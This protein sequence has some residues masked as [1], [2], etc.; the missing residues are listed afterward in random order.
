MTNW[1]CVHVFLR[2]QVVSTFPGKGAGLGSSPPVLA[3][4]PAPSESVSLTKC[5]H[6]PLSLDPSAPDC[7]FRFF[8]SGQHNQSSVGEMTI[9]GY[10]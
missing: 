2:G 5:L 4:R 3:G 8:P 9:P 10:A 6:I 1:E 7:P